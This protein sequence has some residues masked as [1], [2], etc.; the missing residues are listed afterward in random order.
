MNKLAVLTDEHTPGLVERHSEQMRI[1][2]LNN[3]RL[4]SGWNTVHFPLFGFLCLHYDVK[5]RMRKSSFIE[6]VSVVELWSDVGCQW[7][8][9]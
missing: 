2:K 7:I 3:L 6:G 4:I 5:G 9:R 1:G 8:G